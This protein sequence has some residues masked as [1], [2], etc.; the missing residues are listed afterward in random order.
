[1]KIRKGKTLRARLL[2]IVVTT[3]LL[4]GAVSLSAV[5][6]VNYVIE[7]ERL[8][9]IERHIEE[10][11]S[12][13]AATL[14]TSHAL[15]LKGLVLDNVFSD[16][17]GLV[18]SAVRDDPDVTYGL[19]IGSDGRPWA[20]VSPKHPGDEDKIPDDVLTE[21]R[22]DPLARP[23][24][25]LSDRRLNVFGEDIHEFAATVT[26]DDGEQLGTII[27]GFSNRRTQ[28]A[29]LAAGE[30][31][32]K[33]LSRAFLSAGLVGLLS[34]G[35]GIAWVR[36]S[37]AL[38]TGP[39][40][41]LTSAANEIAEGNRGLR[42]SI[43][44]GDEVESLAS[45]FNQMLEANDDAMRKLE[46]TTERA[47]AADR[48]KSEFLANTSHEIRTP[49]NGVLGMIRLIQAMPL[50]PKLRRY[51]DTIDGS[52]NALLSIIND[53]LDFSKM[54]AGKY[55]LQSLSFEPRSVVQEVAELLASRAHDKG[56]ELVCRTAP[57][58]PEAVIGDPDRFRQVLNNLVGNAIKF[59]ESGEVFVD[60]ELESQSEGSV[61]AK[62]AI[63]DTGIGID[64]RDLPRLYEA[65]SQVDGT[66]MR[67]HGGTGLGLA[68][69][70]R[71]VNMMGGDIQVESRLGVGSLFTFT[72][73]FGLPEAGASGRAPAPTTT[74]AGRRVLLVER[75]QTWQKVLLEHLGVWQLQTVC[76]SELS[77]ALECLEKQ[78]TL[79]TAFDALIVDADSADQPLPEFVA[80]V[81][82]HNGLL[83]L[84]ILLLTGASASGVQME[85][86]GEFAAQLHKPLRFSEL[87][88]SL[89]RVFSPGAVSA[90]PRA[91][92]LNQRKR[93]A[94]DPILV[95]DDND[96][97][98]FVA[99]EELA[100]YGYSTEEAEN[101]EQALEM[102]RRR[103]YLCVLMDCQ[104]PVMDGYEATRKIR[105]LEA[106]T[107]RRRTPIIALTAH[108]LVGER[109]R[110]VAAGMDDF[111]SKPFRPSSLD[112]LLSLH[113]EPEAPE[114]QEV[115]SDDLARDLDP[116]VKRSEKLIRLFL[117][118]M[119]DQ[120]RALGA[121]IER[122]EAHEVRA[123][124]H[125][126]K[127]SAL[128]LAAERMSAA[129][130]LIQREA[131]AKTLSRASSRFSQLEG[132]YQTVAALLETEL[133]AYATTRAK[134]PTPPG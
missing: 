62:V 37:A 9:D 49:M 92:A 79:G 116:A 72:A 47:L 63:R 45:A 117:G 48:L 14:V 129:A 68:I 13:K 40:A 36:R 88:N 85:L 28:R 81:R 7:G 34:L 93:A 19:F 29:V 24:G 82:M 27:Y 61:V 71:L 42:V 119:P 101:G 124:A 133:A 38:V 44:S 39:L 64:A 2:Q 17:R 118:R 78:F 10:A 59:T 35:I 134:A 95:V 100:Q 122:G 108:A 57:D 46:A 41:R 83:K 8:N 106:E 90:E 120:L 18:S 69:S 16:V 55:S 125:K 75:N 20:Y 109:E 107:Q 96:I 121:A 97:N 104:M 73:R 32:R 74:W 130:E 30:R 5:G 58:F 51:V 98:R 132:L 99:V 11:I 126:I 76:V 102:V 80:G 113:V 4:T 22:I 50:T 33:V 114:Q 87:Y 127:G 91:V 31:S 15:A 25:R 67:R 94:R 53:I 66:L 70:K 52:A 131:D 23:A 105:Q 3:M 110:V 12:G 128:A 1:M 43:Q 103:R 123:L 65:F 56:L 84:P 77:A 111:L 6:W 89:G 60:L 21:L 115:Q 86:E 112:K 26:G 54:E